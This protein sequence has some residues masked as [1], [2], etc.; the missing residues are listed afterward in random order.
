MDSSCPV[1]LL[2]FLALPLL[3]GLVLPPLCV[4]GL[5]DGLQGLYH[6]QEAASARPERSRR[7]PVPQAHFPL[8]PFH[9]HKEGSCHSLPAIWVL[10]GG[11][12]LVQ[13]RMGRRPCQRLPLQ[14][15]LLARLTRDDS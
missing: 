13:G 11:Q 7:V 10:L 6:V 5:Q 8:C 2:L 3:L 4:V 12:V 14:L 9:E 1:L 15:L